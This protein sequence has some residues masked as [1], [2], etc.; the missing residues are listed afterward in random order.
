MPQKKKAT[1]FWRNTTTPFIDT[2][3][4]KQKQWLL[5][6]TGS[7]HTFITS[8]KQLFG[9]ISLLILGRD[10]G[11]IHKPIKYSV[12]PVQ[13]ENRRKF[14]SDLESSAIMHSLRGCELV[15]LRCTSNSNFSL[16]IYATFLKIYIE[17][18]FKKAYLNLKGLKAHRRIT[19]LHPYHYYIYPYHHRF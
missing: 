17:S 8:S 19:N 3:K 11:S 4:G 2:N 16:S 5:L 9:L 15:N 18:Y 14:T 10:D 12:L 6:D 1:N 7:L 13:D